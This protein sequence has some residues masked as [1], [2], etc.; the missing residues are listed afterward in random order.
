MLAVTGVH[1]EGIILKKG[2]VVDKCIIFQY[3]IL[4][5]SSKSLETNEKYSF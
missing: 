1:R 2:S 3:I 5:I 4:K